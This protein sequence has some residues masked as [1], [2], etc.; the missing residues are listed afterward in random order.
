MHHC[1]HRGFSSVGSLSHISHFSGSPESGSLNRS[2][3]GQEARQAAVGAWVASLEEDGFGSMEIRPVLGAPAHPYTDPDRGCGVARP[4]RAV[5]FRDHLLQLLAGLC[6]VEA[7]LLPGEAQ[8]V[9]A[10]RRDRAVQ[11]AVKLGLE[12]DVV[13][14]ATAGRHAEAGAIEALLLRGTEWAAT[15]QVTIR[16]PGAGTLTLSK[17]ALSR[18]DCS[19]SGAGS[20]TANANAFAS[21]GANDFYSY[22][23]YCTFT[24]I[25]V[26]A[27]AYAIGVNQTA[28]VTGPSRRSGGPAR[29][30]QP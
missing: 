19:L 21:G 11:G 17:L 4:Q 7:Q 24:D 16:G 27:C 8:P 3:E 14:P 12:I 30:E 28:T 13:E 9:P 15:S 10:R 18:L 29:G 1:T 23:D 22:G 20:I 25:H 5:Q 6:V 26:Q 2:L